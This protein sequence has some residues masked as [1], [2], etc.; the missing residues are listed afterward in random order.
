VKVYVE[1]MRDEQFIE[2]RGVDGTEQECKDMVASFGRKYLVVRVLNERGEDVT[3]TFAPNEHDHQ[4]ADGK[5]MFPGC[6]YV[7]EVAR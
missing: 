6:S 3:D 5:C 1:L 4:L 7:N 2:T